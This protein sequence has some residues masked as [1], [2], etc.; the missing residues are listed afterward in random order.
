MLIFIT[1]WKADNL[2]VELTQESVVGKY[3]TYLN[4]FREARPHQQELIRAMCVL[5]ARNRT[6][7]SLHSR[8]FATCEMTR[9][10]HRVVVNIK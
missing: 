6:D 3:S 5:G 8:Q 4:W 9:I 2:S 1:Q 7:T 10:P